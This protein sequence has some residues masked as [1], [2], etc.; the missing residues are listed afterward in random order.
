MLNYLGPYTQAL[1]LSKSLQEHLIFYQ[2]TQG[3]SE[4]G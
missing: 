3:Q 2:A 1:Y 4:G